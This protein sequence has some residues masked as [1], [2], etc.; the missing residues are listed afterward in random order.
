M[1]R[2]VGSE[3]TKLKMRIAVSSAVLLASFAIILGD[4]PDVPREWAFGVVAF[5]LGYWLR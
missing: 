4:Y 5:L 3:R 1:R 2:D